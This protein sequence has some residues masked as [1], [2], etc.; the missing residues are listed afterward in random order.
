MEARIASDVRYADLAKVRL[1]RTMSPEERVLA[2]PRLFAGVCERMK[3]GLR[4]EYP[5]ANDAEID[6]LLLERLARLRKI[7]DTH[8]RRP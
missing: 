1:A 4:D 5:T 6:L 3:E 2:G 8:F 7:E